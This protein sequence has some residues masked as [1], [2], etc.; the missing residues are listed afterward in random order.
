MKNPIAKMTLD[1][2]TADMVMATTNATEVKPIGASFVSEGIVSVTFNKRF[3]GS[4]IH[5]YADIGIAGLYGAVS[6]SFTMEYGIALVFDSWD[7]VIQD[8]NGK[9][10]PKKR[11]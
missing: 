6:C 3:Q 5:K 8:E 2:W 7:K 9:I 11:N 1:E 4:I 10:Y